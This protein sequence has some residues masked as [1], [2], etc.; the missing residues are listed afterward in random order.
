MSTSLWGRRDFRLVLGGGFVNNVGDWLLAVALPAF[1]YTETGSGRSTAAIVVVELLIGIVVGPYGGSLADRWDLRRT[2]I[3]TNLLQAV[4]LLPLLAVT[5]D[6]IWP[7]F[8]VAALQGV[9]QQVNDPAS[10][11][12]VPRIVPVDQLQAANAANGAA[13]SLARLIGSPLGGIAVAAGGLS[14]VVVIDGITF[15]TVAVATAFVR[16]PTASLN[17]AGKDGE[18]GADGGTRAGVR[19]GWR[20]IRGHR[21][22]VGY[23]GV[24]TLA[25]MSFA[26]FPV[27]F[28]AFVVDVLEGDEATIGLIRG[29][30]AFGGLLASYLVGR[31]AQRVAPTLLMAWGYAGLGCVAFVFVNISFFT[32]ALWLF[33]A[34]FAL[35]GLPNMTSQVGAVGTAQLLCPPALLGRFQGLWSAVGSFGAIVG[36]VLVGVLIDQVQVRVLLNVQAACYVLCG[37]GT[38]LFVARGPADSPPAAPASP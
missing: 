24:Q 29:M 34:L 11:A 20:E 1:V 18:D 4:A 5:A 23:L 22:L 15:L 7:A 8:V 27:L 19:S 31:R 6:R 21:R 13:N 25:S 28:I 9:L 16:T 10:F 36:S 38:L 35:S 17:S 12:L 26:M 32:T 14:T 2:V 3:C 37:L 30:A 33:F